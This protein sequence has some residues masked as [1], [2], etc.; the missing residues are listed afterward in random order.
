MDLIKM[1]VTRRRNI[2]QALIF[3]SCRRK[4]IFTLEKIYFLGHE[5]SFS[6]EENNFSPEEYFF[7]LEGY[8]FSSR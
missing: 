3:F 6:S 5:N 2:K 7:S 8:N 1:V 4:S